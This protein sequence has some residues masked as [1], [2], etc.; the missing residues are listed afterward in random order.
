MELAYATKFYFGNFNSK[1]LNKTQ[2]FVRKRKP[3]QKPNLL[4]L[5]STFFRFHKRKLPGSTVAK[6]TLIYSSCE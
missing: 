4:N 2:K 1:R 5:F 3:R 6:I